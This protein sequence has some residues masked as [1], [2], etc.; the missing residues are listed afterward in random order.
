MNALL[1][2]DLAALE[3]AHRKL[4][5]TIGTQRLRAA[6]KAFAAKLNPSTTATPAAPSPAPASAEAPSSS[7]AEQASIDETL[8]LA[9]AAGVG[10]FAATQGTDSPPPDTGSD[11]LA[12]AREAGIGRYGQ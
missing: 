12:L 1:K 10:R 6:E 2:A 8:A 3:G 4:E 5:G 11:T 9:R 7:C